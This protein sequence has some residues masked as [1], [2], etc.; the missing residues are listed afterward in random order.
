MRRAWA[1]IAL[2]FAVSS[3]AYSQAIEIPALDVKPYSIDGFVEI[4][5][6]AF[7]LDPDASLYALRFPTG[8]GA[9]ATQV[10]TRLQGDVSYRN[11]FFTTQTRSVLDFVRAG[12]DW[13]ADVSVYEAYVSLKPTPSFTLDA[14]KKTL[15]WGKGYIW[16]PA[17]FLDRA[18]DPDD[19][20]LAL[21]GF[22]VVSADFIASFDGAIRTLAVTPVLLPVYEHVNDGFGRTGTL[23]GAGRIYLLA[24]DTDVD[25]TFLTG[26]GQPDR[27][28]VDFSRNLASNL[29]LH[30]EMAIVPQA[31]RDVVDAD[32]RL[33]ATSRDA[34]S[35][36]L[37]ARYLSPTNTTFIVDLYRNG[38]GFTQQEMNTYF[39]LIGDAANA[40][41][42]GDERLLA[43]ARRAADA[44]Y[45]RPAA[46]RHYLYG[47]VSQ[48]DA[49]GILYLNTAISTIWNLEDGGASLVPEVTYRASEDLELRLQ[50]GF[51]LGRSGSE[52]G[53]KPS[54]ARVEF[55]GRYYF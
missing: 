7:W 12:G 13:S 5:P 39:H 16:N 52:F 2:S 44:G 31:S 51:V 4:R 49:G 50:V 8:D 26:P 6:T 14:G 42:A 15:K 43:A 55:R 34:T 28:G 41:A 46:M 48:P 47:R 11:G 30:G 45:T 54:D 32:G 10:N 17:A 35:L 9:R 33:T 3:R 25:F 37:G 1:A 19:P 24:Y 36:L 22:I 23:N 20:A 53:E 27:F 29:E 40:I 38:P 18:K 21:E